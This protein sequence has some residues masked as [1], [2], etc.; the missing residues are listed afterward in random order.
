MFLRARRLLQRKPTRRNKNEAHFFWKR[1]S[2]VSVIY[3]NVNHIVRP[4]YEMRTKAQRFSLLKVVQ[5][6]LKTAIGFFS[7]D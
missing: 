1:I 3:S 7:N 6:L 4:H 2:K 5:K